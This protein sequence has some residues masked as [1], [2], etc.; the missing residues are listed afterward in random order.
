MTKQET[1]VRSFI[2]ATL[3]T[4]LGFMT[5]NPS[6]GQSDQQDIYRDQTNGYFTFAPPRGWI[7]EKYDDPR[8]KVAFRH[9]AN[10]GI[11]L[12]IIVREAPGETFAEVKENAEETAKQFSSKGASLKVDTVERLGVPATTTTGEIPG[13]G[14][15]QLTRFLI[16]GL[17]FNIQYAAPSREDF[18]KHLA[19]VRQSIDTLVV[20]GPTKVDVQKA[21]AQQ[22]ASIVR[23]A[24]LAV[25]RGDNK[26][27]C[28]ILDEGL[29]K[30]GDSGDI[31]NR[32][33]KYQC[34]P[35]HAK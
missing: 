7:T 6:V 22:A 10:K 8:T 3:L 29:R 14:F 13:G 21:R 24:D 35:G 30:L 31:K 5:P 9:P 15:T 18:A 25:E 34:A 28:L 27:A 12:R 26:T 33:G 16:A 20:S 1:H 23:M 4:V 17:H 32:I 19:L 11:F 2:A